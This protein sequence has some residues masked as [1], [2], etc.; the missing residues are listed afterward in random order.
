MKI[1]ICAPLQDAEIKKIQEY[2]INDT[3]LIKRRPTQEEQ[4]HL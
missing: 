1:L 4:Y 2:F 3:V